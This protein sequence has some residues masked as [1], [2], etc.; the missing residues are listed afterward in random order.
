MSP[1][2]PLPRFPSLYQINTRV[3]LA[4]LGL[5]LG[6]RATLDDVPDANLDQVASDGFD[7][8][9]LLGIWQTGEAGRQV[10]LTQPEWQAEFRELL[11]DFTPADVSGSP[12]AVR[13]YVVNVD[14][15]GPDA[16]GRFRSRLAERGVR[17]L[18][19]FVP[20]H[21][22]LDHPWVHARPEFYVNGTDG[23]E[24]RE[25]GNYRRVDTRSGPRVLA[26]GRDPYFPGWPDTLQV[27]YRHGGLRRAMREV[28][29]SIAAQ[30]DGVRCDM[31][32]LV[33]PEVIARTW[34]DR[35][36]PADGT[37]P[38]DEPFWPEAIGHVRQARA[39]FT[40]MA[41]AYWDLEWTL[42]QQGFDYTYDK[43]L[44]DRL[45]SQDAP[46]VR[47]HLHADAEFQRRSVRFLENHDEPRAA[48]AFPPRVHRAAA[49]ITFLVPGLRFLHEGQRSGRRRRASNHLSRR[50]PEPVDIELRAFY[51]RL[52]ECV[53]RPVVREGQWRLLSP[54]P[55]WEGN[56]T[57]DRFIAFSWESGESR[58]LVTVNYGP[59][60]GQCYVD[61]RASGLDGRRWR[62][63]DLLSP[64]VIY[65]RDGGDLTRR[66]LYLNL[67]AWGH[68]VFDVVPDA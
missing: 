2:A 10:S 6:R 53:H 17:L 1:L 14:F 24:A 19:D 28:L 33:L 13:E 34:G 36:R 11:P 42:Q 65:A 35:S 27:N 56:P 15:G 54:R 26:H 60:Q 23:D 32:M 29:A 41:E 38:V 21:T 50:S 40:F 67:P 47:G 16:L 9:W 4:E 3:W 22:A 52:M 64:A 30:C 45:H 68:H 59:T 31:A 7:W 63:T 43:R 48:A 20:N 8:V 5:R 61:L 12:F 18:L 46:G 51:T 39:E 37:A 55:A 25:P 49:A 58:L 66:G 62:L 44:Y 57:W